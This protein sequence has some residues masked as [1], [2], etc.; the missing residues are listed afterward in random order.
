MDYKYWRSAV[1]IV[2]SLYAVCV[3]NVMSLSV[4]LSLWRRNVSIFRWMC[5]K[6]LI[7][8]SVPWCFGLSF[9]FV[10][11][12]LNA[13]QQ[14]SLNDKPN[15]WIPEHDSSVCTAW[16]I[17]YHLTYHLTGN[18][19]LSWRQTKACNYCSQKSHRNLYSR[20]QDSCLWCHIALSNAMNVCM[21][22]FPLLLIAYELICLITQVHQHYHETWTSI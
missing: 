9:L 7:L 17:T 2:T 13:P 14:N 15:T 20:L 8:I 5:V 1:C 3:S 11:I 16:P 22:S 6:S 19:L 4:C 10:A 18:G 12:L 21:H